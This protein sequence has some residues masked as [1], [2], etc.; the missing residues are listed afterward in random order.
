M[1]DLELLFKIIRAHA[2]ALYSAR[3]QCSRRAAYRYYPVSL[4]VQDVGFDIAVFSLSRDDYFRWRIARSRYSM[5]DLMVFDAFTIPA[6]ISF[7]A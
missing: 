4:G 5:P 7:S 2:L 1:Y 6:F 3:P